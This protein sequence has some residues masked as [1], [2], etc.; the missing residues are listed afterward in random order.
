MDLGT[1]LTTPVAGLGVP[2]WI[3][4]I[5]SI[6]VALA[7]VYLAFLR[8][9][10]HPLRG[11]LLRQLGYALL[12]NG[13]VGILIAGLRLG[14]VALPPFLITLI[15]ILY[16]TI[17][18]YAFYFAR[19]VYPARAAAVQQAGRNRGSRPSPARLTPVPKP[20]SSQQA[21]GD[22][23]A[24]RPTPVGGRRESRRERKRR[25]K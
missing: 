18:A 13:A 11:S 4:F 5:A 7:G 1:Y 20:A 6:G 17:A 21:A 25:N 19:S 12:G 15:T 23:D 10:S 14:G 3:F 8:S 24:P 2:E 16:F 22:N 9:D